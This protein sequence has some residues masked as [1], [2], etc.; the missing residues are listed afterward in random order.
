[1]CRMNFLK[2]AKSDSYVDQR[3][4]NLSPAWGQPDENAIL[5]FFCG[6]NG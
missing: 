3:P 6:L 2:L 5:H 1:M 4:Q